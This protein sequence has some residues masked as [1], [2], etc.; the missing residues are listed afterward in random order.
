MK[1]SLVE[2][3]MKVAFTKASM[4]ASVGTHLKVACME[5][6]MK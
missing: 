2:A 6:S 4:E 1:V 5:A 3:S